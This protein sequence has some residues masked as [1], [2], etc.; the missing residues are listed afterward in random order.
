MSK[1][2][3]TDNNYAQA[4]AEAGFFVCVIEQR[5]MSS[6]LTSQCSKSNNSCRHLTFSYLLH[7]YTLPGERIL[8]GMSVL[9]W[10]Y[11][12]SDIVGSVGCTGHSAGGATALW[13]S[14]LDERIYTSVISGYFNSFKGSI[15]AM[16]HCEC[17]YV[18]GILSLGEMGDLAALIAPRPLC[19]LNGEQDSIFPAAHAR[20]EFNTVQKAYA[21]VGQPDA[22]ILNIHSGEH[23]YNNKKSID[24]F[25]KW[26]P[27][28][29]ATS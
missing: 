19:L 18:P 6:R 26:L 25:S 29:K 21:L 27:L 9:N 5:G 17:N 20:T 23:V 8:D 11:S 10:L 22:A 16:E 13:L 3:R 4:L 2:L 28:T 15:L 24:W 12:R 7:R 1:R 14:A